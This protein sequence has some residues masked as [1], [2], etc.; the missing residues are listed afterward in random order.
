MMA[1]VADTDD[2]ESMY[3]TGDGD[4]RSQAEAAFGDASE[5]RRR[6]SVVGYWIGGALCLAAVAGAVLWLVCGLISFSNAIDDLQRVRVPG[7]GALD[8]GHG[9]HAIYLE[10]PATASPLRIALRSAAGT[11]VPIE[12]YS[13]TVTY[14]VG[15]HDGRSLAGFEITTPGRYRLTVAGA[16]QTP[17]A[18]VAVGRGLGG[19]LA[20]AFV[21]ALA[22]FIGGMLLGGA[23]IG[24]TAARRS[25]AP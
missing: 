13:G 15:G 18:Y 3:A 8:L 5:S 17:V 24:I 6:P 20:R 10:G 21:G 19:R 25:R 7:S 12:P 23:T 1:S 14:S 4:T 9:R 22:I 11:S 16:A 2:S